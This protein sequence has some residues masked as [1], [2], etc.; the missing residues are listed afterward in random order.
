MR[1]DHGDVVLA[2]NGCYPS[3]AGIAI[4]ELGHN[5][6]AYK[7]GYMTA[8]DRTNGVASNGT[9]TEPGSLGAMEL[10]TLIGTPACHA[11]STAA[12]CTTFEPKVDNSAASSK[13]RTL[14]SDRLQ[15]LQQ[16]KFICLTDCTQKFTIQH[17]D[18]NT[19]HL[20]DPPFVIFV[21]FMEKSALF[22]ARVETLFK[23]HP[24][25]HKV[26]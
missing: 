9:L 20:F 6:G 19:I 23:E 18:M 16:L 8:L 24:C 7:H 13:V 26:Q 14:T 25:T 17:E 12:G 21:P 22:T 11:G 10:R 15:Q 4:R 2:A 1:N 5:S 3:F